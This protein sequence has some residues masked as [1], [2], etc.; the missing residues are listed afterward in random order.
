MELNKGVP[1][2]I[3]LTQ[4]LHSELLGTVRNGEGY[5]E[6]V[7]NTAG[8][9]I[10]NSADQ[11]EVTANNGNLPVYAIIP[12]GAV[13]VEKLESNGVDVMAYY[14]LDDEA[15]IDPGMLLMSDSDKPWTLIKFSAAAKVMFYRLKLD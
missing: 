12:S 7:A 2:V 5:A 6:R 14:G 3:K 10:Y 4:P 8:S 9:F 13:T 15:T 1:T 11:Y